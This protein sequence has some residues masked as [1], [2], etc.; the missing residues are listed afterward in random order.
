MYILILLLPLLSAILQFWVDFFNPRGYSRQ[1]VYISP[2][3]MGVA[4]IITLSCFYEVAIMKSVIIIE[5]PYWIE[6]L[7]VKW[8][9][10]FD[11]LTVSMLIPIMIIS[12]FVQLFSINY[13]SEDPHINR[14]F[15]YL[16]LFSFAML[17]LITGNN[18]L[19]MF[20]GWESVGIVSYL[21]VNFWTTGINNNLAALKALF[22]N[23]IGDWSFIIGMILIYNLIGDLS[24]EIIFSLSP[25]QN[26]S[27]LFC[28]ML[29]FIIASS[30]KS[31][32]IT[33]HSWLTAAMAGPTPV[34]SLLHSS[35]M[36]TAGI[37][38][39]IRLSPILEFSSSHAMCLLIW[40]GSLTALLGAANGLVETDIK[41]IIAY[42]TNSQLGYMIV[43][44]GI[45]QMNLSL[46]HLINHAFFKSLLFLSAGAFIHALSDQQDIRRMGSLNLLTPITYAVFLLGNLSLMAFPFITGFYSKDFLLELL[47]VPYSFTH[48]IA[49]LF[50]LLA[51]F[52]TTIY[53]IRLLMKAHLGVPQFSLTALSHI[54]ELSLNNFV[55][56]TLS[57]FALIL[58]YISNDLFLFNDYNDLSIF[59]HPDHLRILDGSHYVSFIAYLP[60]LFFGS[61]ALILPFTGFSCSPVLKLVPRVTPRLLDSFNHINVSIIH[62]QLRYSLLFYRYLDK[63]LFEYFGPLG[64]SR[65]FHYIGFK[66]ELLATNYINHYN[67]ITA[68]VLILV[69]FNFNSLFF[70]LLL[71]F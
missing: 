4:V 3:L 18:F 23:K 70:F 25:Y 16:S 29:F 11:Q 40:L 39:L 21:L 42:S 59:I 5:G 64:T 32:Q 41:K 65:L 48:T 24:N 45:S 54:H 12:F 2:L 15:S 35:T 50:T 49:Y 62:S 56:I 38:L 36:V 17:L 47:L 8:E 28:I 37:F 27:I 19:L 7:G 33:L 69:L 58:G 71:I 44:I 66:L 34:S 20:L 52:L 13:M 14:F 6:S 53:T 51:A 10:I 26:K 67:M 46:F 61:L 43:I 55:L 9:L 30:A 22:S 60:L 57:I 68:I 31:A 63:G 1:L